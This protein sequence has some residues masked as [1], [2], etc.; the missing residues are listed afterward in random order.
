MLHRICEVHHVWALC[1]AKKM[2]SLLDLCVSSLRRGH[3]NL[4]CIVPFLTDD[5]R[6][7]STCE[8]CRN[9]RPQPKVKEGL[10]H[11]FLAALTMEALATWHLVLRR[12]PAEVGGWGGVEPMR[13]SPSSGP[14][15]PRVGLKRHLLLLSLILPLPHLRR[16]SCVC[17]CVHL[18][19]CSI[20]ISL[21]ST[22]RCLVYLSSFS[23]RLSSSISA[24]KT[25]K[26]CAKLTAP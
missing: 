5:P 13:E 18:D 20:S 4:L 21:T 12:P 6:R 26:T 23:V 16:R 24:K 7:E 9:K 11:S 15:E 22:S 25:A 10:H 19:T 3:A 1:G 14:S 17:A 2:V 8:D